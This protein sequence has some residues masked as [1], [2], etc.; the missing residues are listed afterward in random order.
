MSRRD[1]V[2]KIHAHRSPTCQLVI[3]EKGT[4]FVQ[5]IIAEK[6]EYQKP[7]RR[8]VLQVSVI[9]CKIVSDKFINQ[10]LCFVK[11][12]IPVPVVRKLTFSTGSS[13]SSFQLEV[14]V[15]DTVFV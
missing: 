6:G 12:G 15:Y 8:A 11:G 13:S 5:E 2:W 1:D 9:L 3:R 10:V 14:L 7:E 4:Q